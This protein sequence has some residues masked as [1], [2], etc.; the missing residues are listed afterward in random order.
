MGHIPSSTVVNHEKSSP[1]DGFLESLNQ[2]QGS[3]H[4]IPEGCLPL[5]CINSAPNPLV[6][7]LLVF[8]INPYWL[9]GLCSESSLWFASEPCET[10]TLCL[11]FP[12]SALNNSSKVPSRTK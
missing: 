10:R 8:N 11:Q 1:G 7:F 5:C 3:R 6:C 9:V 2:Y 12:L 4:T